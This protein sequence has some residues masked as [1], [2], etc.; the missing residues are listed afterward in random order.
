MQICFFLLNS[1]LAFR[2]DTISPQADL[3]PAAPDQELIWANPDLLF[4]V[5]WVSGQAEPF[6]P[7][8]P[9]PV[10]Q[11]QLGLQAT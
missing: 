9:G 4:P 11:S 3:P 5:H 7:L 6:P 10:L 1:A 2:H 8:L